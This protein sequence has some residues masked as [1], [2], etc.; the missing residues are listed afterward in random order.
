MLG[1]ATHSAIAA[2]VT[3]AWDPV[4]SVAG[5]RLYYGG[6]TRNYTNFVEAGP[7]TSAA[8]SGLAS[9]A[10]YFFA[11]TAYNT[12]GI[13]SAFSSEIS[14]QVPSVVSNS[15]PTLNPIGDLTLSEDAGAQTVPFSGVSSGSP[16]ETQT[17]NVTATSSN[18]SLVPSLAVSY[19]SPNTSGMVS[20]TPTA[21][22]SGTAV[23]TVT[24][25]DGQS[26]NNTISRSFN[27][28]VQ[29][30][31]DPPSISSIADLTIAQGTSTGA[32]PFSV[33]DLETPATNL[34]VSAVA[35][36][37]A[38]IPSNGLALSGNDSSRSITVTP[39][40]DQNGS[41]AVTLSVND[42]TLTT[43]SSFILA[44]TPNGTASN[45]PPTIS[46]I[47]N[48]IVARSQSTADIPLTVGDAETPADQLTLSA[49]WSNPSLISRVTFG[50]SG[51]NRTVKVTP[52]RK[53][54]GSSTITVSV[55]DGK[56]TGS[57][58]FTFQ[59]GG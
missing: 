21:N 53:K 59:V 7:S 47:P 39:A 26:Q 11:A 27:V 37:S 42:G 12:L 25:N 34:Q 46:A 4:S 3:L 43:S 48:Q 36:N 19:V 24:V 52:T 54:A 51:A 20:L 32:I 44:V 41:S 40:P 16:N 29:S 14:Y 23:I 13:E 17:L 30:I 10:T 31:N 55:S 1:A 18:P 38:L 49:A 57:S 33:A 35:S 2:S 15:P 58:T 56:A 28:V 5:Y 45:T 6:V 50:G 8:V 9:G 22:M